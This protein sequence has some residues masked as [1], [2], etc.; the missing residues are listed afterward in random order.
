[1]LSSFQTFNSYDQVIVLETEDKLN[2]VNH[3]QKAGLFI[4]LN[5]IEDALNSFNRAIE[6]QP[7]NDGFY[8]K[9]AALLDSIGLVEQIQ[10]AVECLSKAIKLKPDEPIYSLNKAKCLIKLN[11]LDEA[12]KCI[13]SSLKITPGF[14]KNIAKK[15]FIYK[16]LNKKD[17]AVKLYNEAF[18]ADPHDRR[19][20]SIVIELAELLA[21]LNKYEQAAEFFTKA[22]EINPKES[23]LYY[24]KA[25]CLSIL[26]KNVIFC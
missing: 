20:I 21:D 4:E 24:K 26:N 16:L 22:I 3:C 5:R 11:K 14:A 15:A 18:K 19:D 1:M 2:A 13:D 9:K 7:D 6:L 8:D 10:Q 12:L 17:E 25:S 23:K